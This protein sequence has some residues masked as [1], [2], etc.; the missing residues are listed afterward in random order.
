MI[1][2]PTAG[3]KARGSHNCGSCDSEVVAIERYSV[4]GNLGE[5]NGLECECKKV[6]LLRYRMIQHPTPMGSGIH[7]R[8]ERLDRLRAP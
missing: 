3:G 7:R 4:S 2:H 8:G 1:V 5:F 6:W